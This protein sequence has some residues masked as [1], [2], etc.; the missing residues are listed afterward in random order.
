MPDLSSLVATVLEEIEKAQDQAN[1]YSRQLAEKYRN[2]K[3]LRVFPV[4]NSLL[5]EVDVDFVFGLEEGMEM[6]RETL[7][8]E[9]LPGSPLFREPLR[10]IT[11]HIIRKI[12]TTL[13]A[14]QQPS[15]TDSD[16]TDTL[17]KNL[18]S[19]RVDKRIVDKAASNLSTILM[20]KKKRKRENQL[21]QLITCYSHVLEETVFSDKPFLDHL[22]TLGLNGKQMLKSLMEAPE[23]SDL[24]KNLIETHEK[25]KKDFT[26]SYLLQHSKITIDS[27]KLSG[28][29]VESL[30][31]LHLKLRL[32]GYKWVVL[33]KTEELTNVDRT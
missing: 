30:N 14:T 31:H 24:F 9:L 4:P 20:G 8:P 32:E 33:E 13:S 3:I 10:H 7:Q 22:A 23:T 12:R 15:A 1:L 16:K 5:T 11:E 28:L 21:A 6:A 18:K 17:L 29:P 27:Q 25:A 19:G 26:A 2:D